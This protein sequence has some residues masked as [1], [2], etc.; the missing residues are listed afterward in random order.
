MRQRSLMFQS[1]SATK[2]A[3]D[4]LA[5]GVPVVANYVSILE[6]DKSRARRKHSSAHTVRLYVSILERD[7]SRA[8]RKAV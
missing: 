4:A 1:S 8:R 3:P 2:A 5:V 7:K 6:R